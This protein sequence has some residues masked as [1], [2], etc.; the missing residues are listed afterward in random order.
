MEFFKSGVAVGTNPAVAINVQLGWVPDRVEVYNATD[1]NTVTICFPRLLVIKFTSGGTNEISAGDKITGVTSG[2]TAIVKEV[3]VYS[4]T[5]AAGD[6]AGFFV[7][8]R[9]DVVGT[10]QSENIIGEAAGATNDA[11]VILQS[12][13]GYDVDTEVAAVTTA[14]TQAAGYSGVAALAARGFTIG[15][16]LAEAVKVLR[17]SAWRDD[18]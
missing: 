8:E 18:R 16:T 7:C 3:L 17:W 5:W 13:P 11:G 12:L 1:G 15:V 6:I 14:A 4:G 9:E 10:F 2:A